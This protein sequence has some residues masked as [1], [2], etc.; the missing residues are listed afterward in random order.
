[1][2]AASEA[3]G[4]RPALGQGPLSRRFVTCRLRLIHRDSSPKALLAAIIITGTGRRV[5]RFGMAMRQ[6]EPLGGDSSIR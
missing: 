6:P 3:D 2:E 4:S 1:V 5:S